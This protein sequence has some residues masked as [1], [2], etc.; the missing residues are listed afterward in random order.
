MGIADKANVDG[1]ACGKIIGVGLVVLGVEGDLLPGGADRVNLPGLQEMFERGKE[2]G[3]VAGWQIGCCLRHF[4]GAGILDQQRLQLGKATLLKVCIQLRL[5]LLQFGAEPCT[6]LLQGGD[7]GVHRCIVDRFM[8]SGRGDRASRLRR[9]RV[10]WTNQAKQDADADNCQD[11]A[12]PKEFGIIRQRF[13][14]L[15]LNVTLSVVPIQVSL[16]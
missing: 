16:R 13:Y 6:L 2:C 3:E 15:T 12:K 1:F 9:C 4:T 14:S 5:L 11:A 7:A 10:V 8:G